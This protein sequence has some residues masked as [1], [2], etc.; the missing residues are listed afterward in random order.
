MNELLERIRS[1]IE[2]FLG[3]AEPAGRRLSDEQIRA[4]V[5]EALALLPAAEVDKLAEAHRAQYDRVLLRC[6]FVNEEAFRIFDADPTPERIVAILTVDTE[7]LE[8][9]AGLPK[10]ADAELHEVLV[11]LNDAFDRR[12]AAMHLA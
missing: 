10:A 7:V 1:I 4:F 9:A 12:D 11:R 6:E 5:G 3:Y 2:G 8:A